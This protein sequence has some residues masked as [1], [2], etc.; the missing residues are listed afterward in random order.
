M[1]EPPRYPSGIASEDLLVIKEGSLHRAASPLKLLLNLWCLSVIASE[2]LLMIKKGSLHFDEILEDSPKNFGIPYHYNLGISGDDCFLMLTP[3]LILPW[4]GIPS[5]YL[6][7]S[8]LFQGI[9]LKILPKILEF[10][11]KMIQGPQEMIAFLMQIL[12]LILLR[13]GFLPKYPILPQKAAASFWRGIPDP[14][15]TA[16]VL[17]KTSKGSSKPPWREEWQAWS[18]AEGT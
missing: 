6:W 1:P 5:I 13:L 11:V 17:Q 2:N 18:P 10:L 9:P 7:W 3:F 4:T 15:K 16:N 14:S 8:F 12:F